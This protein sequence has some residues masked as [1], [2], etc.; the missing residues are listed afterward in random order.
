MPQ[1]ANVT[2]KAANGTTDVVLVAKVPSSGDAS[3]ARWE[4]DAANTIR[5]FRPYFTAQTRYNGDRTGRREDLKVS[6]PVVRTIN[7][8]SVL[9]GAVVFNVSA[10]LP[11]DITDAE[12]NEAVARCANF[13]SSALVK[14][15]MASGYAPT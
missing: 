3:P 5:K 12:S 1:M 8:E 13:L 14:E 11:L 7:G 9:K 2:I 10:V 6:I 4:E 15:V